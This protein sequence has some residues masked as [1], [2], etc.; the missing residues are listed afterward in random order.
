MMNSWSGSSLAVVFLLVGN[1]FVVLGQP[2]MEVD[3]VSE[4][5]AN[6]AGLIA[7]DFFN[8]N[9]FSEQSPKSA[10]DKFDLA[11]NTRI[12]E[13][14]QACSLTP[15]QM[16]KLRLAGRVEIERLFGQIESRRRKFHRE[17]QNPIQADVVQEIEMF[18]SLVSLPNNR[19]FR[20]NSLL[21]K[22]AL[23]TLTD[24]QRR[25]YEAELRQGRVE[26]QHQLQDYLFQR[27]AKGRPQE[28]RQL[29]DEQWAALRMLFDELPPV[30][31]GPYESIEFFH[32]ASQL[33]EERYRKILD[34]RQW[35]LLKLYF[36]AMEN[37]RCN[38]QRLGMIQENAQIIE[39]PQ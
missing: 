37:R 32:L 33:P 6:L 28:E 10:R 31:P 11:L 7:P 9:V 30:P 17:H 16:E 20:E 2:P 4:A 24:E 25:S 12:R 5:G 13:L 39:R 1:V 21:D 38:L 19:V 36:A 18:R 3:D 14:E 35:Q 26:R 23:T 15:Q 22:V 8:E 34:H 29:L 27:L